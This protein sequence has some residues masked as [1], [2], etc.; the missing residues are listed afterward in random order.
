VG[1][2]LVDS[3]DPK[4]NTDLKPTVSFVVP[5][6][7]LAHLLPQCVN[8]LLA[9]TYH[10]YE[11]LIMDN[12]SPDDTPV[13][14]RAFDDSRVRHIRNETNIGHLR[15]FNKGISLARGKYV[16][17]ISPDDLL[18]SREA[19]ERFVALLD[20]N[21]SVGYV[22]SRALELR[23]TTLSGVAAWTDRGDDDRIW[24]GSEFLAHLIRFNFVAASSGL[25]RREC[26]DKVGM[27]PLDLGHAG[28]WYLWCIIACYFDVAYVAEP[29]ICWR[30][31]PGTLTAELNDKKGNIC[32]GEEFAVL[33][34]IGKEAERLGYNQI[35]TGCRWAITDRACRAI[36][37]DASGESGEVERLL[38]S[39]IP[40]PRE[41]AL[42]RAQ[43][44]SRLADIRY[45]QGKRA[46][47]SRYYAVSLEAR[48]W[49]VRTRIKNTL[50]RMDSAGGPLG[51]LSRRLRR[52]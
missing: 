47:A 19:L 16:W 24:A 11:I 37:A 10:D 35:R 31:Y 21:P 38:H 20:R 40:D 30:N 6:Y 51:S 14:A 28:D 52:S 7:K 5:C 34:R 27:F 42:I 43:L 18:H 41:M 2:L 17:W 15:N 9:Q 13:V 32:L 48:P 3:Q 50:L 22:F 23:D 12:C 4:S 8:S 33:D 39:H 29:M 25:V 49:V 36:E 46:E 44:Y 1:E 45:H 26:Y